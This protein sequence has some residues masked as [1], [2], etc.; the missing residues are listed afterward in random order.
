MS[1]AADIPDDET[2]YDRVLA[3][4]L[5]ARDVRGRC[6]RLGPALETVLSAHAYPLAI[7]NLLAEA[8]VMCALMGSLIK[9]GGQLTMQAQSS[10][11]IVDMLVCDYRA[12][13][14]R[15]YVQHDTARV[16]ELGP[17]SRL[18][19][20]FG[21]DAFLAIT[22]DLAVAGGRYQ[23][24][25]PLDGESLSEACEAY[26]R[27]SEQLPTVLR[28]AVRSD[29][30]RSVAGGVLLQYLPDGE[31]GRE[32]LHV[33]HDDPDWEHVAVIGGSVQDG[34]LVDPD[35]SL[36]AILW[37]LFHEEAELRVERREVVSRGCRCSI[38][39]YRDVLSRFSAE[40]LQEMRQDDGLVDVDC[41]FCSRIFRVD[42]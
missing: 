40:D 33:R 41:A 31:E 39:H 2:G 29:A 4:T 19:S 11:G 6:V 35:L 18:V 10:G 13:E 15:G 25:V 22:F 38:E 28:V 8:L 24:I 42:V 5:P 27:Q 12:G 37:R 30:E 17:H 14:L 20:F 32:R 34:E 9:D 26:F 1:E 21:P 16:D 7:R 23:G 3:F 36:E